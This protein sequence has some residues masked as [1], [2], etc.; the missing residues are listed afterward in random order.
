MDLSYGARLRLQ[1]EQAGVSLSAIAERTKIKQ[2]LLEGLERDN[3]AAWP[4]GIF[5]RS[6][7]RAYAHAIG[8]DP[9]AAVREFLERYPD[10]A[11]EFGGSVPEPRNGE[12]SRWPTTRLR[13][14]IDSAVGA[15]PVRRPVAGSRGERPPDQSP[16][17][18]DDLSGTVSPAA[19]QRSS[20]EPIVS[21]AP[22]A[23]RG[24]MIE[25][26]EAER[27]VRVDWHS[28]AQLC[29]RLSSA[30]DGRD[31]V[32][33]LADAVR[34]LEAV[35]IILWVWDARTSTLTAALAHGYPDDML[36]QLPRV[37]ADADNAIA[38]AFLSTEPRI[39]QGH[40]AA[41]GAVVVPLL[42]PDGCAGV[43]ALELHPGGESRDDVRASAAILA[44]Q[45]A[46]LMGAP[47]LAQAATA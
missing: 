20:R 38:T 29:T 46:S 41:T 6:Y 28:I 22:M 40:G 44:A 27:H 2:S 15:L 33:V 31:V 11:E 34:A 13:Y 45:L 43:L 9:D 21:R 30:R 35:G 19:R 1:R 26:S 39:V 7:F 36:R 16:A 47:S 23:P 17:A 5:R 12:T 10:P 3:V 24:P 32:P 8:L 4:G 37:P 25:E 18:G 42:T 14:L